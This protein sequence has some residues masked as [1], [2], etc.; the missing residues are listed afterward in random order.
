MAHR[1]I[2]CTARRP[3]STVLHQASIGG[4]TSAMTVAALGRVIDVNYDNH[5]GEQAR[6]SC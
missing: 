4:A 1:S 3:S 2:R 6:K 5:F